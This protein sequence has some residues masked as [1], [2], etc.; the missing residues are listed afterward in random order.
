VNVSGTTFLRRG[1]ALTCIYG[2]LAA[3]M[4]GQAATPSSAAATP[5]AGAQTTAAQTPQA[6]GPVSFDMPKSHNPLNAYSPD[7]VPAPVLANSARLDRLI[8][9]GS[10]TF[11]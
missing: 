4:E 8:R 3:S 10:S 7:Y 11:H 2:M 1:I 6:S 9:D 5:S